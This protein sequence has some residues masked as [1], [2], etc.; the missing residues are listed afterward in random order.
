M[1]SL[2]NATRP[3]SI[4]TFIAEN[5]QQPSGWTTTILQADPTQLVY[6]RNQLS[7]YAAAAIDT[8]LIPAFDDV[9]AQC[10]FEAP[11]TREQYFRETRYDKQKIVAN[12]DGWRTFVRLTRNSNDRN[13]PA[14]DPGWVTDAPCYGSIP[15]KWVEAL[16]SFGYAIGQPRFFFVNTEYLFPVWHAERYMIELDPI[17][18]GPTQPF[19]WVAYKDTWYNVFCRSRYRQGIVV[20]V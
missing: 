6:W 20:P 3:Y 8:T 16:D 15:V 12:R 5:G 2:N 7:N 18:G 11:E 1:E 13:F 17:P 9:W 10:K 4:P 19:S 14:N